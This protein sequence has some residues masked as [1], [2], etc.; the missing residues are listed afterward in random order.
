M[1]LFLLLIT[2]IIHLPEI[3]L[4]IIGIKLINSS[5]ESFNKVIFWD[6][7]YFPL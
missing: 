1:I 6:H 2:K 5:D 3:L 4:L 7:I